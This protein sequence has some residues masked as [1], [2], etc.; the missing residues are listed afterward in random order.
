MRRSWLID[1]TR[2][3]SV[4]GSPQFWMYTVKGSSSTTGLGLTPET[5]AAVT[6]DYHA[7]RLWS[8]STGSFKVNAS[9][10]SLGNGLVKLKKEDGK[11]IDVP[12]EKLSPV[13]QAFVNSL[14]R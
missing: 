8:D 10:M 2:L 5:R 3:E 14:K 11:I 7:I 12:V 6:T 9:F 1:G 4:G 13:D